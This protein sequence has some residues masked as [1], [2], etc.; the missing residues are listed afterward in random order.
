M[1]TISSH[2]TPDGA[3]QAQRDP[4][5]SA[6]RAALL[7]TVNYDDVATGGEIH[8]PGDR[9]ATWK[10]EIEATSVSDLFTVTLTVEI[11][12]A[13][14]TD[15][16]P[17]TETRLLLRPLHLFGPGIRCPGYACCDSVLAWLRRPTKKL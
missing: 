5:Y 10:G 11:Q 3:A 17:L 12:N 1:V 16:K 7:E 9:L 4:A 8:L 13:D 2:G 15:A 6:A 14:G